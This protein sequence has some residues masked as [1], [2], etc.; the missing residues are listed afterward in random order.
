MTECK[1]IENSEAAKIVADA[2]LAE[3]PETCGGPR[4][5]RFFAC[6]CIYNREKK[7]AGHFTKR[8]LALR[9]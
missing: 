1:V 7:G 2:P 6:G 4:G 3:T 8:I 9:Q 5:G